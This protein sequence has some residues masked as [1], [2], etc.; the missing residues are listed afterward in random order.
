M[1]LVRWDQVFPIPAAGDGRLD[2]LVVAGVR[3]AV[4]ATEREIPRWFAWR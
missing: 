4:L 1:E 3:A 2:E